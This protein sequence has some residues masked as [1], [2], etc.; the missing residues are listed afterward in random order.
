MAIVTYNSERYIRR[1]LEGILEQEGV[2]TE[3]VVVDNASSDGTRAILRRFRNRIRTIL[4]DRNLGFAEAQN[5]AIRA[6]G[7]DWVL[8]LNPDV[9]LLPHFIRTLRDAG[10]SDASAGTVCGKLLSIGPNF[11][12]LA[13]QRLDSTGIF[14]T[15]PCAIS[16][17]AGTNPTV[18]S[19]T[20]WSTSSEPAPQPRS[21][22]GK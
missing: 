2:A 3:I 20:A 22:A 19:S 17:A 11:R 9:L 10:Q 15:P 8:T 21:T 1:C 7:A 4:N 16:T 14:F 5:Q 6:S 13:E 12:P 18:P